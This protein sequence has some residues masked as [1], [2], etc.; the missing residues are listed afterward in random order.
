MAL[1]EFIDR[2]ANKGLVWQNRFAVEITGPG[3]NADRNINLFAES[4][5]MP[6]QNVRTTEDDLRFGPARDHAQGFTYGDISMTFICTPGMPEKLYF[7]DWQDLIVSKGT[8]EWQAKFY[9]DYIG[10]IIIHQLDKGD[11]KNYTV[12]VHEAFPKTINAQEFSLGTG[13]AYQTVGIE[14]AYRWWE[15]KASAISGHLLT[16]PGVSAKQ[17][18]VKTPAPGPGITFNFGSGGGAGGGGAST[19]GPGTIP[20]MPGDPFP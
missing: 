5:S 14:F 7:E 15:S 20:G 17:S 6:G 13:D 19:P 10:Q 3:G 2:V 12:T 9:K 11:G 4:V 16:W 18:K 8:N 1:N